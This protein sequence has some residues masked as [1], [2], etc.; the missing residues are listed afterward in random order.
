M[1]ALTAQVAEK[2]QALAALDAEA[3]IAKNQLREVQQS[4]SW[5]VLQQLQRFRLRLVPPESLR[6]Q[7][8]FGKRKK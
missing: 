5:R 8:L 2:E 4:R 6:E 1:Q 7:V 3:S